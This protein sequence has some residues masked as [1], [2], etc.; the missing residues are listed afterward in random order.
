MNNYSDETTSGPPWIT[1]SQAA[2]ALQV[3]ERTVQR[4]AAKGDL[5]AR[6]VITDDGEKWEVKV[7]DDRGGATSDDRWRHR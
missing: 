5:E 7:G 2:A 3:S 6:K 4:R 1:T